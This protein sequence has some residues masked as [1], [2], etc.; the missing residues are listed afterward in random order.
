M[1]FAGEGRAGGKAGLILVLSILLPI[2]VPSEGRPDAHEPLLLS[3]V[4]L[5][6][7]GRPPE[8]ESEHRPLPLRR[9]RLGSSGRSQNVSRNVEAF[10]LHP[11]GNISRPRIESGRRDITISFETPSGD[12]PMHG[13]HNL[14]VV[15]RQVIGSCLVIRIAKWH[16]VH[17]SCAWGHAY[18]YDKNRTRAKTLD[19]IPLEISCENLWDGNFHS[20]VKSGDLLRF[21]VRFY[22]APAAGA[23]I[24]LTSGQGWTKQ[25]ATES[26]GTAAFQLIRDYYPKRWDRFHS[27]HRERFTAVAEYE[28]S[29]KGSFSGEAYD[30]IRYISSI[31][32]TYTPSRSDY[33]SDLFGLSIGFFAMTAAGAGVYLHRERRRKPYREIVFRE[34]D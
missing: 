25:E 7:K 12:G 16:T 8:F 1:R 32:W 20:D 2:F 24:R 27:R 22:G 9:Y 31:P 23:A 21:D 19:A 17:H 4:Q 14:Y 15:D 6:G 33:T 26:D 11:A 5:R 3:E 34:K 18:K 30:R 28:V 13:V 10:V 29:Q